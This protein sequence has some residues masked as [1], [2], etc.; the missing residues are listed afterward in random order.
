MIRAYLIE[1]DRQL[2]TKKM[3][4]EFLLEDL[5]KGGNFFN[6]Q[7]TMAHQCKQIINVPLPYVST[8]HLHIFSLLSWSYS[9]ETGRDNWIVQNHM[10]YFHSI[11]LV[12]FGEMGYWIVRTILDTTFHICRL[13]NLCWDSR[14][15]SRKTRI[16]PI[17]IANFGPLWS[18]RFP[19]R[20][21][22]YRDSAS[23]DTSSLIPHPMTQYHCYPL[24]IFPFTTANTP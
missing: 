13:T 15:P 17:A 18:S 22:P 6:G 11:W 5:F 9:P 19:K 20:I 23:T 7:E 12:W 8:K 2:L 14:Y 16:P 21:P 10:G 3:E 1:G 24:S 4:Q